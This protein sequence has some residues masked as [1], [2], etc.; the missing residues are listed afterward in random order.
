MA[1][2]ARPIRRLGT[3][4]WVRQKD[5]DG[6]R[7]GAGKRALDICALQSGLNGEEVKPGGRKESPWGVLRWAAEDFIEV[8][9]GHH[10]PPSGNSQFPGLG[11]EAAQ[12]K[13]GRGRDGR[14]WTLSPPQSLCFPQGAEAE[15]QDQPGPS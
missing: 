10:I 5:R 1:G 9:S 12:T 3:T 8:T 2:M 13:S 15:G 14:G 6:G 11:G 7:W 4:R